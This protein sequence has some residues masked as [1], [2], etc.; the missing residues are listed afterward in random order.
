M[1]RIPDEQ[2]TCLKTEVSIARLVEA[3]GIELKKHG[4][5]RSFGA[6][7]RQIRTLSQFARFNAGMAVVGFGALGFQAGAQGCCRVTC[8]LGN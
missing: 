3:A 6:G 2:I 5:G 1:V 7:V 4:G 8:A